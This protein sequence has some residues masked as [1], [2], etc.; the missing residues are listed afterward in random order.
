MLKVI[1]EFGWIRG[2]PKSYLWS[3]FKCLTS[4]I[5]FCPPD[6]QQPHEY[7]EESTV[8]NQ[9]VISMKDSRRKESKKIFLVVKSSLR[10][11]VYN[12]RGG[13]L[14][15]DLRTTTVYKFKSVKSLIFCE[16]NGLREPQWKF[17]IHLWFQVYIHWGNYSIDP[18]LQYR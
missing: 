11:W 16:P 13:C 8:W 17:N 14:T 2:Q 7:Y 12:N 1:S 15:R 9:V 10:T 3:F 5:E 18:C 4:K 6:Q